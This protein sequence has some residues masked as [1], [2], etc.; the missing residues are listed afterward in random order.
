LLLQ[1]TLPLIVEP[2]QIPSGAYLGY[3][4]SD[5]GTELTNFIESHHGRFGVVVLEEFEKAGSDA[6]EALLHPFESGEW[7]N[8]KTHTRPFNCS[9][10]IFIMTSNII[11]REI[12]QTLENDGLVKDF[13][14]ETNVTKKRTIRKNILKKVENMVK[15]ELMKRKPEEFARRITVIP[16]ISLNIVEQRIILLEMED[17]MIARYVKPPSGSRKIGNILIH[18][19]NNFNENLVKQYD[20]MQGASS[21]KRPLLSEINQSVLEIKRQDTPP[22]E[23]WFYLNKYKTPDFNFTGP[24]EEKVVEPVHN[25]A[26]ENAPKDPSFPADFEFGKPLNAW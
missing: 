21:L 18:F 10:I 4:G 15:D 19:T 22:K 3:I 17:K 25:L 24:E 9:K 1:I 12:T 6:R 2:Y 20:P 8:K 14:N 23:V 5:K 26:T 16:F 7:S 13:M 11:N